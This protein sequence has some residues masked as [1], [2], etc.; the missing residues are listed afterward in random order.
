MTDADRPRQRARDAESGAV[1]L[2]VLLVMIA[3]LGM[4]MTAL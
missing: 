4:G 3:L 1:L 2:T